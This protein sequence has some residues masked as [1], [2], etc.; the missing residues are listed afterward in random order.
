[1]A[2]LAPRYNRRD[3]NDRQNAC[4]CIMCSDCRRMT[5][6]CDKS[7]NMRRNRVSPS[8]IKFGHDAFAGYDVVSPDG[9]S[10]NSHHDYSPRFCCSSPGAADA[11]VQP[12]AAAAAAGASREET[13]SCRY[14]TT[15]FRAIN[16]FPLL[17]DILSDIMVR[18]THT[19]SVV[20]GC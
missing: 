17:G 19:H 13:C 20:V 16:S 12:S 8:T 14:G 2:V 3:T 6:V 7:P 15:R 9:K 10:D 11:A 4:T 1:M 18:T 5:T